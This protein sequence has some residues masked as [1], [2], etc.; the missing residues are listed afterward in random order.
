MRGRKKGARTSSWSWQ[1]CAPRG[2]TTRGGK[3]RIPRDDRP[4]SAATVAAMGTIGTDDGG[5]GTAIV[6]HQPTTALCAIHRRS[7]RLGPAN[8][9][10]GRR[11][12]LGSARFDH[13]RLGHATGQQQLEQEMVHKVMHL[14][15]L[16][17]T[18]P[19]APLDDRRSRSE[20]KMAVFQFV[21]DIEDEKL[22]AGERM[23]VAESRVIGESLFDCHWLQKN[24]SR[25]E[26]KWTT[27]NFAVRSF[28]YD[29]VE[30]EAWM[31]EQ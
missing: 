15:S 30:A 17:Q 14:E 12:T 3:A 1:K 29:C 26:T 2:G 7:Q 22:W 11:A 25:C 16:Q 21:R 28:L 6:R 5:K 24:T 31:S 4:G 19:K 9:A 18:E 27:T 10:T 20:W 23:P 13:R 8:R